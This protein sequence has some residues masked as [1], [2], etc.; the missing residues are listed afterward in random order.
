MR[1]APLSLVALVALLAFTAC[2]PIGGEPSEASGSTQ[3][4]ETEPKSGNSSSESD[5]QSSGDSAKIA[6]VMAEFPQNFPLPDLDPVEAERNNYT[7]TIDYEV[8]PEDETAQVEAAEHFGA[9]AF[10]QIDPSESLV[11]AAGPEA[12]IWAW[13]NEEFLAEIALI[14]SGTVSTLR[15][16][17]DWK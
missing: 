11:Q 14:P 12:R 5:G 9:G 3:A 10:E 2:A 4:S 6:E 17:V 16:V 7:W 8:S 15:Y 13:E 1:P